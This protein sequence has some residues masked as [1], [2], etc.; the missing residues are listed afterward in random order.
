MKWVWIFLIGSITVSGSHA[1]TLGDIANT[2]VTSPVQ[3]MQF[4]NPAAIRALSWND[5]N[6]VQPI[7]PMSAKQ[8]PVVLQ[9]QAQAQAFCQAIIT[10]TQKK[11]LE[12][13]RYVIRLETKSIPSDNSTNANPNYYCVRQ[14]QLNY[15]AQLPDNLSVEQMNQLQ[16]IIGIAQQKPFNAS[17]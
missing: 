13:S 1:M 11:M 2:A 14:L 15:R 3:P 6:F 7:S 17:P 16:T 4:N 5:F 12:Q 9:P 10:Q 8:R